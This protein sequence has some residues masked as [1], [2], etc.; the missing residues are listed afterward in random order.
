MLQWPPPLSRSKA[1]ETIFNFSITCHRI[2][3]ACMPTLFRRSRVTYGN[4]YSASHD[5]LDIASSIGPY[6]NTLYVR[7]SMP[8]RLDQFQYLQV[9]L[10]QLHGLRKVTIVECSGGLSLGLMSAIYAAPSL[11]EL[12]VQNVDWHADPPYEMSLVPML[13]PLKRLIQIGTDLPTVS[14]KTYPNTVYN[15]DAFFC[16]T[17]YQI[18]DTVE[19][20]QLRFTPE[21]LEFLTAVKW[22]AMQKLTLYGKYTLPDGGTSLRPLLQAMPNLHSMRVLLAVLYRPTPRLQIYSPEGSMSL[23]PLRHL[24]ISNPDPKD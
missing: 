16:H 12:V 21:R 19:V 7:V 10:P 3:D 22:P 9:L 1:A 8:L 2:R 18:R 23:L 14:L 4:L 6:M 15:T 13:A 11:E 5:N 17:L 24:T 20:V